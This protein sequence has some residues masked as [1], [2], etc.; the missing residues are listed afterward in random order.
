VADEDMMGL[1]LG[2]DRSIVVMRRLGKGGGGSVWL[3]WDEK[4]QR[5]VALKFLDPI[6][7]A[8]PKHRERFIREGRRFGTLR[9]A[10][11]VRVH[12][13]AQSGTHL[14][15][16]SEF[17][18]GRNL[19]Q[20][21]KSEGQLRVRHALE[22]TRDVA[23]GLAHAHAQGFVHRDLK[24]ENIMVRT[25]DGRVKVLDFGIAKDLNATEALTQFG[26]YLGTPAYSA[27]EQVRG[28]LVDGRSDVFSLGVILY[29]LLSGKT[30]FEGRESTEILRAT[31]ED[32]PEPL[33]KLNRNVETPVAQLIDR[34]IEKDPRRRIHDMATVAQELTALLESMPAEVHPAEETRIRT[35]LR[36]FFRDG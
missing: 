6:S 32:Q 25:A 26:H 12:G 9:H 29:E 16:I 27:P 11:I 22:I 5:S 30:A 35:D 24:P 15:L 36:G 28:R 8:D 17:V 18:D 33:V 19:H 23:L 10:N 20:L 7:A 21:L 3:G 34:M 2:A 31:L 14:Y 4:N 1:R 13:L